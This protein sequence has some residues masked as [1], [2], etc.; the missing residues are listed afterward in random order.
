MM[1]MARG[2]NGSANEWEERSAAAAVLK[3][4]VE[5]LMGELEGT[6]PSVP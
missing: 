5:T 4:T 1:G 2:I 6:A 3:E